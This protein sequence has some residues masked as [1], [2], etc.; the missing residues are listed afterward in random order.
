MQTVNVVDLLTVT[1][2]AT[3][4]TYRNTRRTTTTDIDTTTTADFIGGKKNTVT[5]G[6]SLQA[7]PDTKIDIAASHT[8]TRIPGMDTQ[9][10]TTGAIAITEYFPTTKT[11]ITLGYATTGRVAAGVEAALDKNLTVKITGYTDTK[12]PNPQHGV[13]ANVNYAFGGVAVDPGKMPIATGDQFT[14]ALRRLDT[15]SPEAMRDVAGQGRVVVMSST[16]EDKRVDETTT[17]NTV[18]KPKPP[19]TPNTAPSAV[20]F[21]QATVLIAEKLVV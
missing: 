7:T 8:R 10:G 5:L 21:A 20:S 18:E 16:R 14:D 6:A 19:E 2:T 15:R 3:A 17:E 12:G 13:Y 1:D 9:K 11:N 4:T